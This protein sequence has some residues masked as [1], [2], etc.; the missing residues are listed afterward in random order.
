M[1]TD[2]PSFQQTVSYFR[3]C[4]R[5]ACKCS[6]AAQ[7]ST[8]N[9]FET[10]CYVAYNHVRLLGHLPCLDGSRAFHVGIGIVTSEGPEDQISKNIRLFNGRKALPNGPKQVGRFGLSQLRDLRVVPKLVFT[11]WIHLFPRICI[12]TLRLVQLMCFPGLMDD[13]RDALWPNMCPSS[14]SMLVRLK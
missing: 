3:C 8:P 4:F 2:T 9:T 13:A 10:S 14:C 7:S 6:I 11:C 12:A 5:Q 1:T